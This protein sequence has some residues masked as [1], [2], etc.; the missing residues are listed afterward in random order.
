M[1]HPGRTASLWVEGKSLGIFG[2]LHPQLRQE[3][4]LPDEVYVFQLDLGVLVSVITQGN[5]LIR[6]FSSYSTFPPADRDI[7]FF[8]PVAVSVDEIKQVISKA[9][10]KLLESI[11]LFDEYQGENVPDGQRSLAFRL[12]YRVGDRTLSDA[13]IDPLQ[14]KV[15]DALVDKLKVNL[16][17]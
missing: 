8:I 9:A 2:Q 14:Q 4:E 15:R 11:E 6:K 10:G 12:I 13:D 16:R 7:A 5:I 1:L 3:Q 17:S